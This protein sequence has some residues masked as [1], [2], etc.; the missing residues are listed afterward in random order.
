MGSETKTCAHPGCQEEEWR[1]GGYCSVYCRDLHAVELD[2]REEMEEQTAH[3]LAQAAAWQAR[4]ERVEGA[5]R[6]VVHGAPG[7]QSREEWREINAAL[8]A[9][10]PEPSRLLEVVRAAVREQ[11][12]DKA[13]R[14]DIELAAAEAHHG[15]YE[16]YW[17]DCVDK[18]HETVDRLTPEE[19]AALGEE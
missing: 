11:R 15:G 5:L 10:S 19:R 2:T 1:I 18:L 6:D 16:G 14:D 3:A 4:A 17:S 9:P 13:L 7:P 12:A 8:S